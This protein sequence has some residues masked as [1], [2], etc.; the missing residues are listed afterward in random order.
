MSRIQGPHSV[1]TAASGQGADGERRGAQRF[2]LFVRTAKLV[3]GEQDHLCIVRDA[4]VA[5]VKVRLFGPLPEHGELWLELANGERF[6]IELAWREDDHAGF[7]FRDEADLFRL[8]TIAQGAF[9]KRQLRLRT[10]IAG[11]IV[12]GDESFPVSFDN[13]S[14]QG[15]KAA[16][17]AHLAIGQLVRIETGIVEPF[18]AKVRWRKRPDYGLIFEDILPFEALAKF[19]GEQ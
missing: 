15:A 12:T 18:Y 5:G 7:R 11:S 2:S 16:C 8:V 6:E 17:D 14:Q 13:I 1:E 3:A 19:A 10:R 9:P 4:S